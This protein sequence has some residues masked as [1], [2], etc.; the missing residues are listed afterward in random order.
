MNVLKKDFQ[1]GRELK[2][3]LLKTSLNVELLPD[4]LVNLRSSIDRHPDKIHAFNAHGAIRVPPV[5]GS[6]VTCSGHFLNWAAHDH[7][8]CHI[9]NGP[10]NFMNTGYG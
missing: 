7:P 3:V 5:P 4:H 1:Q 2:P 9:N 6:F 10:L 8:A